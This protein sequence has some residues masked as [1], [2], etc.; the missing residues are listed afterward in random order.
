M[1]VDNS[2]C[3]LQAVRL[4]QSCHTRIAELVPGNSASVVSF[5]LGYLPGAG[6]AVTTQPGTTTKALKAALQVRC[7]SSQYIPQPREAMAT[8]RDSLCA[9]EAGPC[10]GGHMPLTPD[11]C[12]HCSKLA[13][14]EP[15]ECRCLSLVAS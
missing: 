4:H 7:S 15:V 10:A 11:E 12:E 9:Q 8:V 14:V 5:N 1:I 3:D 2:A 6:H 13:N